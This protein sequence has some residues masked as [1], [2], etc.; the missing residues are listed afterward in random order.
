MIDK[1]QCGAF[2][3]LDLNLFLKENGVSYIPK[4]LNLLFIRLDR[5]RE[6]KIGLKAFV[7]ET[8]PK[9]PN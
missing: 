8:F 1:S 4:E 6:G 9:L 2:S 5:S 3:I 7:T